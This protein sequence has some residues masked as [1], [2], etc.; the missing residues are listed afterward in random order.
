MRIWMMLFPFL[1]AGPRRDPAVLPV[2]QPAGLL[3]P[4]PREANC[5]QEVSDLLLRPD[6]HLLEPVQRLHARPV[7]AVLHEMHAS[8]QL[9]RRLLHVP[10]LHGQQDAGL[11]DLRALRPVPVR[12]LLRQPHHLR[13]HG[14][15]VH[16]Q[17]PLP[18]RFGWFRL[19]ALRHVSRGQVRLRGWPLQHGRQHLEGPLQLHGLQALRLGVPARRAVRRYHLQRHVRRVPGL[20]RGIFSLFCL[21]CSHK[22]DGLRLRRVQERQALRQLLRVPHGHPVPRQHHL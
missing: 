14:A 16:R 12:L 2:R 7:R 22:G 9:L 18:R 4:G 6:C 5:L 8:D 17:Q 10:D 1:T 20:P 13:N 15:G 21:E 19:P 3:H 11:P